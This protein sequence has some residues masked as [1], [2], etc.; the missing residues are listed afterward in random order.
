MN[1]ALWNIER[2]ASGKPGKPHGIR[3]VQPYIS[4]L[5]ADIL[6]LTEASS[7]VGHP[8][9][10]YSH[11]SQPMP[12]LD[13]SIFYRGEP[14]PYHPSE[15]RTRIFSRYPVT[16]TD[17]VSDPLTNCCADMDTP[18]GVVRVLATIVGVTNSSIW[19]R[20]FENLRQD[21]TSLAIPNLIL[22]G[23]FNVV[24]RT[25][26][27]GTRQAPILAL[28]AEFDLTLVPTQEPEICDHV[29][30]GRQFTLPIN[31]VQIT[32]VDKN[33]SDHQ[34]VELKGIDLPKPH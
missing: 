9:L 29:V 11:S 7:A 12:L 4:A 10:L 19:D 8:A 26:S 18:N 27:N 23:D 13:E 1:I 6:V 30:V 34:I 22:A 20:D 5:E 17:P 15:L 2:A 32:H 21:L 28:F 33:T 14:I 3:K 25:S 31:D 24:M 16:A